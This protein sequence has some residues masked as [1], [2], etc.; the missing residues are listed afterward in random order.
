MVRQLPPE[1]CDRLR[2]D[3]EEFLSARPDLT[4][5]DLTQQTT[6]CDS[7]G[8]NFLNG[9]LAGGFE[10]VGQLRRV[11]DL[12]KR[13]E[14]LTPSG[15][16]GTVLFAETESRQP[17]RATKARRFFETETVRKIAE[18]LDYTAKQATI[19]MVTGSFGAGKTE[20]VQA[21]RRGKGKNTPNLLLELDDF[22][23]ASKVDF[24]RQ[25]ANVLDL[26][27]PRGC[28]AGAQVFR[29]VV[30]KL[31]EAPCLV[32]LD[33]VEAARARVLQIVR[34]LHDRTHEAGVG[35]VLLG[36]PIL[37]TRMTE[38]RMTDLGALTSRIGIW[39][40][41]NGVSRAEMAAILKHEGIHDIEEPAFEMFWRLVGGSMRRLVHAIELLHARHAGKRVDKNTVASMATYLWGTQVRPEGV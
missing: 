13:G 20:A 12:A 22:L 1:I 4:M 14:I 38:S 27:V 31:W 24:I 19:A 39:V 15:N 41:V 6:L 23:L 5:L 21:W 34:Q 3:L 8:R 32:I 17:P 40:S 2:T 35:I 26:E 36:A 9:H 37:V 7:A 16:N 25:V 10:V 18:V 28:Q 30:E 33:Q 29:A 11:L